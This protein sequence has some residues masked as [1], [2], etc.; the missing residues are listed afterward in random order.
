M[1]AL[2]LGARLFIARLILAVLMLAG[3]GSYTWMT[4]TSYVAIQETEELAGYSEL[5]NRRLENLI[6]TAE[7]N[8]LMR[9]IDD[10]LVGTKRVHV[11]VESGRGEVL[12]A[13]SELRA[14]ESLRTSLIE[15]GGPG[16]QFGEWRAPD[17]R[18]YRAA[19]GW[20]E[21]RAFGG[22]LA[23]SVVLDPQT[24]Q[25]LLRRFGLGLAAGLVLVLALSLLASWLLDRVALRPM[26]LLAAAAARITPNRLS[27]RIAL[28]DLPPDLRAHGETFNAMLARLEEAFN[29]LSD[30]SSDLAHELRTPINNLMI[31]T[32]VTLASER[33]C[34]DYQRTLET[35]LEELGRLSRMV[36]DM[37]FLARADTRQ[38]ALSLG[39]VCIG[40]EV[41]RLV[42]MFEP[43]AEERNVR[44]AA[45]G[46]AYIEA[47]LT[48]VQRAINN[49]LSNALRHAPAGGRVAVRIEDL[50][51][52]VRVEVENTGEPIPPDVAARMFDRFYR[53]E[54]SREHC[55]EGAGLGLA[56]VRSIMHLHGGEVSASRRDD[57]NVFTLR[58]PR[59]QPAGL[60]AT[61]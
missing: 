26:R 19:V 7:I 49:L 5:I 15:L 25:R 43:A 3:I 42:S 27:M 61:P 31:Q 23:Y 28:E 32:Q 33:E 41:E 14:P 39:E 58:F 10:T 47:D 57:A 9:Q 16:P 37:L 50:G 36:S 12:Y 22:P 46:Q 56:L 45:S 24:E 30:F 1:I 18:R 48:M 21:A 34:A 20:S 55:G 60:A 13:T 40:T 29:R 8:D 54:A 2:T 4:L 6:G 17:G 53:A 11:R 51:P 35:N 59:R 44:L 52:E 38:H